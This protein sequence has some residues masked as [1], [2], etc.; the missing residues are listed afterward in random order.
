M[1]VDLTLG[2]EGRQDIIIC[3]G[4]VGVVFMYHESP[5]YLTFIEVLPEEVSNGVKGREEASV[6]VLFL[7]FQSHPDP[8]MEL[9]GVNYISEYVQTQVREPGIHAVMVVGH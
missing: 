1:N 4:V 6:C 9:L 7:A 3:A 8:I 2:T 5:S